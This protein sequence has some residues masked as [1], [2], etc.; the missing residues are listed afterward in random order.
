MAGLVQFVPAIQRLVE[1]VDARIGSAHAESDGSDAS[2]SLSS[3][4]VRLSSRGCCIVYPMKMVNGGRAGLDRRS[5]TR[6]FRPG[7]FGR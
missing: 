3:F 4:S 2:V 5:T 7:R 6:S 1:L